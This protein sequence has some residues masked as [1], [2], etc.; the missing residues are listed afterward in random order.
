MTLLEERLGL[1]QRRLADGDER[2]ARWF[3]LEVVEKARPSHH[4]RSLI[5]RALQILPAGILGEVRAR[6]MADWHRW[7]RER[8]LLGEC[9]FPPATLARM[10]GLA[11]LAEP[12]EL[13]AAAEM[14]GDTAAAERRARS[15][16]AGGLGPGWAPYH[17]LRA[18]RLIEAGA[19]AE[20]RDSLSGVH[21]D[22]R[23]RAAYVELA[24]AVE[25]D[26]GTRTALG[27]GRLS[28][29]ADAWIGGV[30]P[31]LE[32][33]AGATC[34]RIELE[35]LGVPARGSAVEAYWDGNLVD[36][37]P[38]SA[39][40]RVHLPVAVRPGL[41]HRLEIDPFVHPRLRPGRVWLRRCAA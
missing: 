12:A 15:A 4:H 21:R 17:L 10:A 1:A 2:R 30:R 13:A 3:A 20:A 28:W 41:F 7:S 9:P 32:I 5:A 38:V 18:R 26:A 24:A 34:E 36:V 25:D 11:R 27:P 19:L 37:L 31:A 8:C 16:E 40:R 6:R 23:R 14:A 39:G 22:W 29:P 35:L 33:L